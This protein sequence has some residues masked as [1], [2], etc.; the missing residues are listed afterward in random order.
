M[1]PFSIAVLKHIET[2]SIDNI[3]IIQMTKSKGTAL[4]IFVRILGDFELRLHC[5]CLRVRYLSYRQTP[6]RDEFLNNG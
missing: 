2:S 3:C 5:A 4:L 1:D 6:R